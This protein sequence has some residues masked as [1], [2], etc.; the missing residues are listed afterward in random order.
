MVC[1]FID[2]FDY[3]STAD[4][5]RKW[6]FVGSSATVVSSPI[7]TG[8]GGLQITNSNSFGMISKTLDDQA[9]WVVGF[10]FRI[11]SLSG[12]DVIVQFIDVATVQCGLRRLGDG[13]LQ[14]T[15]GESTAVANGTSVAAI[16][17]GIWYYIEMKVTISDSIGSNTCEVYL[18]GANIITVDA[19]EDLKATANA[20]ADVIMFQSRSSTGTN[21]FDD[22]YIFDGTGAE[23]ND[24]IGDVKV[25][26]HYPDT[27]GTTSD[28]LGSDADSVDNYL[29]VDEVDTDDDS[30]YVESNTPGDIDLYEVDD[31]ADTPSAIHAVQI[32][33][34]S[35]KVDAGGRTMRIVT[36]PVSTNIFGASI[37]PS[38]ASYVNETQVYD[39]DPEVSSAWTEST[40][41]DTEFGIEVET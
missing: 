20:S 37:N 28:F 4:L 10:A 22:L 19:A 12:V 38:A 16:A 30:T 36:R 8:V 15:R 6:T 29:L 14:V 9:S 3:Y 26:A 18:N 7:R 33:A 31:F 1:R 5:N 24:V 34:V 21:L 35:K 40:F 41:N 11:G 17:I 39:L 23:N 25:Q 13:T 32:N 2:G 27:N